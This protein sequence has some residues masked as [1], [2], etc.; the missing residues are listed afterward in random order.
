MQSAPKCPSVCFFHSVFFKP[1]PTDPDLL[2]VYGSWP[3]ITWSSSKANISVVIK[4]LI[5]KAKDLMAEAKA[6]A[7]ASCPRGHI[8]GQ[9]AVGV[10]LNKSISS[11]VQLVNSQWCSPAGKVWALCLHHCSTNTV[12]AAPA[13]NLW[14]LLI[15]RPHH[16][17]Y[18]LVTVTFAI[19]LILPVESIPSFS[20]TALYQFLYWWVLFLWLVTSTSSV[21]SPLSS[22]IT[23]SLFWS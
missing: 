1:L 21:S 14:S 5:V 15:V 7:T 10:M 13:L 18:E 16:P 4:N 3:R 2:H 9:N 17:S 20:V 19:C 22:S 6:K 23:A 11:S 12:L 8:S